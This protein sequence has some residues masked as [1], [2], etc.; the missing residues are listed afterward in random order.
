M[1]E[2][3]ISSAM[4]ENARIKSKEMGPLRNSIVKGDGNIA[5][6]IGEQIAL[7]HLGGTWKNTYSYDII[8][9]D[10]RKVDVKTKRTSVKP[11]PKY[12]CSVSSFN[13][14]QECDMYTFVRV[15]KDYSVG[16][17]LGSMDKEEYFQKATLWKKG[18]VDPS[19]NFTIRADCYNVKIEDLN[20]LTREI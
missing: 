17:Y 2:I 14:K 10:G 9:P 15:M 18:D 7:E 1:K 5:G 4:I 16:W 20:F 13:T 3:K 12:D 11:N 6:F 8:L 19:N